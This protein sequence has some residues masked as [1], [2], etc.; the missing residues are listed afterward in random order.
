MEEHLKQYAA[1]LTTLIHKSH[2]SFEK[3]LNYISAGALGLSM[4]LIERVIKDFSKA[5]FTCVLLG[6]WFFLASTLVSN[7]LSHVYTSRVHAKTLSEI[8]NE[9]YN[10]ENANRRNRRINIWNVVSIIFLLLGI[11][12]QIIFISINI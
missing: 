7:L 2:D 1:E 8:A 4:I 5:N 6:S 9:S 11:A 3:Q 12:L 10:Y